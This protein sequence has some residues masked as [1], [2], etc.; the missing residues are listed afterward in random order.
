MAEMRLRLIP[1]LL[2]ML[3]MTGCGEEPAVRT[4]EVTRPASYD[5]PETEPR[6]DRHEAGGIAWVWSVP[7]GWVDA[8]EVP[9]QLVADYRFKGT[10]DALPG[11]MTVSVIPGEAGGLMANVV[12]W[13][14]QMFATTI[15]GIGPKDVVHSPVRGLTIVELTG[16]YQGPYVPTRLVGAIFQI[17]SKDGGIL[18]TWFFKMVG[19]ETTIQ[20]NWL[21]FARVFM[22]FRPEGAEAVEL[23]DDLLPPAPTDEAPGPGAGQ[24]I[25]EDRPFLAKPI[26][27]EVPR[28]E[29]GDDAEGGGP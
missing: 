6:E 20:K 9:D 24:E 2:T 4:Y 17:P 22:S 10:G 23:P 8:P 13:R 21:A 15:S 3:V 12:R 29:A 19:D 16:Q 26:K 1:L 7:A 28:S 27:P 18:Q 14:Q 5:W 25:E 11:R